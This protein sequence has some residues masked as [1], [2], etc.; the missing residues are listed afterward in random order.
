MRSTYSNNTWTRFLPKLFILAGVAILAFAFVDNLYGIGD[1]VGAND[2][3]LILCGFAILVTGAGLALSIEFR[4]VGQWLLLGAAVVAVTLLVVGGFNTELWE[5][6][7]KRPA[8]W[9]LLQET[10]AARLTG[11]FRLIELMPSTSIIFHGASF[12]TNR[13]GMRDKEYEKVP[14]PASYR[15]ALLGPSYVMG[16]GVANDETFEWLL[17]ERLNQQHVGQVYDRYEILNFG[18]AGY[19]ALQELWQFENEVF[20]FQPDAIFFVSHHI[21]EAKVVRTLAHVARN[22]RDIP[23]DYL[24]AAVRQA[25]ISQGMTQMEAERRLNPFG[26]DIVAWSYHQIATLALE[27]GIEAVWIFL[28]PPEIDV[29]PQIARELIQ[30][31]TEAGFTVIDLSDA[32]EGS[33]LETLIVAKWDRHP[34]A[35]GHQLLADRLYAALQAEGLIPAGCSSHTETQ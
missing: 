10:E 2:I 34:N 3:S 9:P 21:E 16:S 25:G 4:R 30:L 6:Y 20:F 15:I 8:D 7:S 14:A 13:W 31:A 35:T 27:R 11:D 19:S 22:G 28:L 1:G 18:V 24:K 29:E 32:Y 5:I 12:S 33:D 23:Y 26:R 17:E